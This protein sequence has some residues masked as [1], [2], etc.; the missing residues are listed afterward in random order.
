METADPGGRSRRTMTLEAFAD[1]IV[2]GEKR[3]PGDRTV[4]GAAPGPGAVEAGALELLETPATGVTDGL[5]GYCEALDEHATAYAEQHGL[6]PDDSVPP[7]VALDFEDRTAIVRW[8]TS[9][10]HPEKDLWVLLALF[11]NMAF[12]TGAHLHTTEAIAAGHPGLA[13]M[14]FSSP[15][16]DGLWRFPDFSYRRELAPRHPNT[17]ST[18]SPA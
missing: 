9:P 2:P 16:D 18:G 13:T 8:L 11:C 4:A 12:D 6:K 10:G 14:G 15:D 1:T 7:F 5:D 3:F 17:T